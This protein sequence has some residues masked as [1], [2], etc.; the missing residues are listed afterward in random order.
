M[1]RKELGAYNKALLKKQEF[2]FLSKSDMATPAELKK[3][4]A[5]LKKLNPKAIAISLHDPESI[6]KVQK[7]L[8]AI[9]KGK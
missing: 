5:A 2:L 4:L 9:K 8:N 7:I 6:K 3:K 1:I